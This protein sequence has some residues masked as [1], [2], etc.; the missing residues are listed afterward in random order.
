MKKIFLPTVI[1]F[2]KNSLH[3]KESLQQIYS[4]IGKEVNIV[5][6]YDRSKITYGRYAGQNRWEIEGYKHLLWFPTEDFCDYLT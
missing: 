4:L 3:T 1:D 6:N 2:V 5:P